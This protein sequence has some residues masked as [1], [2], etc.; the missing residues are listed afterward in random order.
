M[1]PVPGG[2]VS[3]LGFRLGLGRRVGHRGN[4]VD[5]VQFGGAVFCHGFGNGYLYACGQ[6]G[7]EVMSPWC[8]R[9]P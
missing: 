3:R 4:H 1:A 5:G 8:P 7:E 6:E 9:L 2:A